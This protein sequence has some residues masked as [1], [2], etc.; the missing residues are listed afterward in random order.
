MIGTIKINTEIAL[1]ALSPILLGIALAGLPGDSTISHI[2]MEGCI[3]YI[4][5]ASKFFTKDG[6]I[7]LNFKRDVSTTEDEWI[8]HSSFDGFDFSDVIKR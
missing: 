8:D 5:V 3:L 4:E 1:I 2:K 6:E 7:M